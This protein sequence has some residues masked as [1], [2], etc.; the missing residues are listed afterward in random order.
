MYF[1]FREIKSDNET[2]TTVPT[3]SPSNETKFIKQLGPAIED[4]SKRWSMAMAMANNQMAPDNPCNYNF[5]YIDAY[6][7]SHN[8][9][10]RNRTLRHERD[11][12]RLEN[13]HIHLNR[14]HHSL[15]PIQVY[16]LTTIRL[17]RINTVFT[18]FESAFKNIRYPV[19]AIQIP[20]I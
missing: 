7:A 1:C 4:R 14:T 15:P 19:I 13:N 11:N 12:T 17:T 18:F 3:I 20:H 8:N 2:S 10:K 16:I 9:P 6:C 5:D